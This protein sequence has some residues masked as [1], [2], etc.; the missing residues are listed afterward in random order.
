MG[1]RI[2]TNLPSLAALRQLNRT[3]ER[4]SQSL[5]RLSTGLRINSAA[6]DPFGLAIAERLRSQIDGLRQASQNASS[7]S[8]L[9]ATAEAALNEVSALLVDIREAAVFALNTGGASIEQIDA[10]QD[11]VDNAIEAIDRIAAT[12]RFATRQLLSGASAFEIASQDAEIIDL[13]PF[14]VSFD[15]HSA[16]TTFTLVVSQNASQATLA[17]DDG[18][19]TVAAGGDVTLRVTGGTGTAEI[20]LASGATLAEATDAVNL[21]RSSTGVYASGGSL[22]SED[23]G[24]AASIRIEQVTGAG[25]FTGAG[26]A[27][28]AVGNAAEDGGTDAAAT[29]DGI[30]AGAQGNRL[31]VVSSIFTGR[32]ELA[33]L[34]AAGTYRFAIAESGL[35]FQLSNKGG[36]A[37]RAIVG[38]PSVYS[39]DLGRSAIS[40]G[41]AVTF[42]FLASLTSGGANDLRRDPANALAVAD[43]AIDQVTSVRAFLGSFVN[44]NV[45]PAVRELSVHIENLTASESAIR[46]LDLAAETAELSKKQVL[47][48]AGI[49]VLAQ[50]N[51]IPQA[52][53]GLLS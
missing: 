4:L 39:Q 29:L 25:A 10:E 30:P 52:V 8:N 53:I 38:I 34:S 5:R 20:S 23:F 41:G 51:A 24:S 35:L 36:Q 3:D 26:G 1:L 14:S 44:D 12:T 13:Q 46:D 49:S 50:A 43:A 15:P 17:M 22:F 2:N 18:S 11:A 6:D 9:I 21:L 47:M 31:T 37:D 7:A 40:T 27:I 16:T 48:Q 45:E 28:A 32:L 33:P 19:G 42:G